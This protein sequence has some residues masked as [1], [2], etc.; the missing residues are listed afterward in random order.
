MCIL[1]MVTKR[2]HAECVIRPRKN[3]NE[4]YQSTISYGISHT[5]LFMAI[6]AGF[7]LPLLP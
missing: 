1:D 2:T 3:A 6:Y 4:R 7:L 5:I